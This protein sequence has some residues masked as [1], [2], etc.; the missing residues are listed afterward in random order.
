MTSLHMSFFLVGCISNLSWFL[1]G[2]GPP[3]QIFYIKC[4]RPQ[5]FSFAITFTMA[6]DA[7]T[8]GPD[9]EHTQL[10]GVKINFVCFLNKS[11]T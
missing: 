8:S 6:C 10:V 5:Y 2:M 3:Q 4:M 11:L 7:E 1:L 9:P